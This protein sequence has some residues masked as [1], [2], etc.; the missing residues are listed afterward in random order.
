MIYSINFLDM[1]EQLNPLA[2]CKYLEQTNW[3]LYPFK[4]KDV[5]V[6]QYVVDATFKQV[7]VP[8]NKEFI[9]YKR[10]MYNVV[11]TVAE[12]E[13]KSIEQVMLYLLNPNTDILRIRLNKKEIESGN[14]YLMMQ[15][16]YMIIRRSYWLLLL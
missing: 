2:V 4:R 12:L 1:T 7:M 11:Q 10:V 16:N 13:Q 14:I 8:M 5:K 3:K 9:D 15:L 6:F